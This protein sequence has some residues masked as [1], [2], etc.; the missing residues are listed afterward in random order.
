MRS[1]LSRRL[2]HNQAAALPVDSPRGDGYERPKRL[3]PNNRGGC[4]GFR[5]RSQLR[6]WVLDL[7]TL[8]G[9][10]VL[11]PSLGFAHPINA[12]WQKLVAGC[13][14][15]PTFNGMVV[16]IMGVSGSGKS[17]VGGML[18]DR[19]GWVFRDGDEFHP[20]TN[21]SKMR[22]GNPLDDN[23]RRPWLLAIQQ[24]MDLCHRDGQSCVIACSALKAAYRDLLRCTEP[25]VRLVHLHGTRELLA[26]RMLARSG[27]FMPAALLDSQL[28]TLELP[29]DALILDIS[30]PPETLVAQIISAFGLGA[31]PSFP[32]NER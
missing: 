7:L 21:V 24:F 14:H 1:R 19:L 22:S 28:A 13:P 23:D 31:H 5:C 18:A 30:P 12:G 6:T 20:A 4:F 27:H 8:I 29:T 32:A 2:V 11:E 15:R 16:L 17:T 26:N 3:A 9:L 25:W 10:A